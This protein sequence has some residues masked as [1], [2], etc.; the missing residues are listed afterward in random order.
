MTDAADI[1]KARP[2]ASRDAGVLPP[3]ISNGNRTVSVPIIRRKPK[4][5]LQLISLK[6]A[7]HVTRGS[8]PPIISVGNRTVRV[9][10][11]RKET[12]ELDNKSIDCV[13]G[14]EVRKQEELEAGKEFVFV[15]VLSLRNEFAMIVSAHEYITTEGVK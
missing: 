12:E 14:G 2:D 5:W 1:F 4:S 6:L 11:I 10:I 13:F 3:I 9:P 15:P 8:S 7:R